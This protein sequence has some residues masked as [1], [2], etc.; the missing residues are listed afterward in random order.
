MTHPLLLP[1]PREITL[2]EGILHLSTRGYIQIPSKGD[3]FSGQSLQSALLD[4]GIDWRVIISSD[5][6]LPGVHLQENTD[7]AEQSYTLRI[8]ENGIRIE[9]YGAGLF[10]AVCTLNQLLMQYGRDLPYLSISDAADFPARG[11]MLDVSRDKVP[12]LE[13]LLML[14]DELASLKINQLQLYIEHTFAYIGHEQVWEL[15]SALTQEDI[16][17]LDAYCKE[18]YIELV[19]NQNS[20]GHME[21]WLKFPQYLP[22]AETPDGFVPGW[23]GPH[24]SASTLD[25]QDEGSFE[26]ITALYDQYLPHFSSKLFNVGCDEPWELGQGKSKEAVEARGGRV[27]LDW[28]KKLYADVSERGYQMMFWGDIIMHHPDLVPELP[29]DIIVM[30]WGYEAN[31]DFE[32]HCKIFADSGIPFY[33]CPGTSSWN[34]LIGRT[35]NA[36]GN[37][38]NAAENGLKYGAIGYLNTDWGDNGHMQPLPVS[39]AGFAYGAALSWNH[40]NNRDIDLASALSR[41]IF[42]DTA[43]V[44]GQIAYDAGKAYLEFEWQNFNGH[45]LAYLA[46]VPHQR[47]NA[48]AENG[49]K[50]KLA[51]SD[52]QH[53]ISHLSALKA[54]LSET[55]MQR[56]DSDL[57]IAEYTQALSLVQHAAKWLLFI[58]GESEESAIELRQEIDL[59][60]NNAREVWL[61][62]NRRGGLEDSIER[63]LSMREDYLNDSA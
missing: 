36:K 10:Y 60:I 9:G 20:L 17:S 45:L 7:L 31:H 47:D 29:E 49:Y 57:I 52:L 2:H 58:R 62:R 53:M 6:S 55:E 42:R 43:D 25:P 39:F 61:G 41:F 16:L 44:M 5:S 12:T 32:G 11:V 33:V 54:R 1:A 51:A 40:E 37:L 34:T 4:E 22:L 23:G 48:K 35:V 13:T 59:L 14:V 28:M 3:F 50:D 24:R 21:R 46:Q 15:A 18:R 26:L 38:Q 56:P 27:Y 63:L 30:E 8:D 19:P